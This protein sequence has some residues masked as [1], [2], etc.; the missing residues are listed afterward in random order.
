MLF[1]L[2]VN[3]LY[4]LPIYIYIIEHLYMHVS[5]SYTGLSYPEPGLQ[6]TLIFNTLDSFLS[7]H[8]VKEM[9]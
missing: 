4:C 3:G 5:M 1:T 2:T 9:E 6:N 7:P 8:K